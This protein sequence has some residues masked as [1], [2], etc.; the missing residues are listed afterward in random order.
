QN[1]VTFAFLE[2]IPQR[3]PIRQRITD[4]YD[5]EKFSAP[6]K[7]G[8]KYFFFKNDGLQNQNVLYVQESLD[9]EPR[10]LIDPNTWSKDGTIAMSGLA[11]SDDG[12]FLA[13]G[14]AEAGSDWNT[15]KVLD[16]ASAKPLADELKW[17]KFSEA[18]WTADG[19]GFFYCRYPEPKQGEAFQSLNKNQ[20]LMYH[21]VGSLQSD[22]VLV[23]KRPDQPDWGF[24]P[25]ATDDGRYLVITIW[26][27]TD[28]RYGVAYRDL[29]EPLAMPIDLIDNFDSDF[30]FIDNDGPIF[31]FRTD[32]KAPN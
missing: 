12:K 6:F 9:A 19:K 30:T 11:V 10:L 15:W 16:V 4:L 23:Y 27:G 21:R 17:V 32:W 20:Q 1:K 7:V 28:D 25:T 22:D 24:Q 13:Y 14:K 29:A 26:Q 3:E 18:S 2:S 31:Y 5:Y 8:G